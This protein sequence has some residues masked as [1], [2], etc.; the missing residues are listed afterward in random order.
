MTKKRAFISFDYDNDVRYRDLLVG[1]AKHPLSSIEIVDWSLKVAF[2]EKWMTQCRDWIRRSSIVIQLVGQNTW[3]AKGA[4]WEVKC[5]KA[6]GIPVLGVY[7]DKN[8][9]GQIPESLKG[10]PVIDWT[11]DEIANIVKKLT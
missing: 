9:K 2:D 4:V 11:W 3:K 6:E 8:N 5:A 7:I 1:Q 10:S